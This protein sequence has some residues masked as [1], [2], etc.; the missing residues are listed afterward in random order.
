MSVSINS[1][2]WPT[3][4]DLE[5]EAI[6]YTE[7]SVHHNATSWLLAFLNCKG[8]VIVA[9]Y[10]GLLAEQHWEDFLSMCQGSSLVQTLGVSSATLLA[11]VHEQVLLS[12]MAVHIDE[13]MDVSALKRLADHLLHRV[14]LWRLLNWR[15]LPLSVEVKTGERAPVVPNYDAIRVKHRNYLENE[16]VSQLS[17]ILLVREDKFD[18]AFHDVARVGFSRVNSWG[19]DQAL[20]VRYLILSWCEICYYKHLA[21]VA[22]SCLAQ[23]GSSESIFPIGR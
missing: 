8:A 20:P 7:L 18:E 2:S 22:C 16:D 5:R 1:L 17:G 14:D 3:E 21:V 11:S 23:R 4:T 19:E 10:I 6:N 15:G 13:D 9:K 12:W